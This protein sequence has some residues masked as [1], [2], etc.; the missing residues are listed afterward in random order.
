[1]ASLRV[2]TQAGSVRLRDALIVTAAAAVAVIGVWAELA[3][4]ERTDP[5]AIGAYLLALAVSV[6]LVARRRY[7]LAVAGTGVA[8]VLAY[9][10]LGYPGE[11]P[12][13]GLFVALFT[14]VLLGDGRVSLVVGLGLAGLTGF[15]PAIPNGLL[16]P[17]FDSLYPTAS[18]MGVVV[19]V[20]EAFRR[21]NVASRE[22]L[23][24]AVEAR[25]EEG[26]R[27]LAEERLVIARELHDVLAHTITVITVQSGVALD[28]LVPRPEEARSAL[29][30]I[31]SA[32]REA[33][34]ELR[35]TLGVLRGADTAPSPA[36]PQPG[37]GQVQV[38]VQ[39]ARAAGI[40]IDL[41][42]R[43]DEGWL[44]VPVDLAAYRIVQEALTNVV[45]H[46]GATAVQV[47]VE[48]GS[49][50]LALE[51]TDNGRGPA[52]H[53]GPASHGLVGMRERARSVGGTLDV[54]AG[55]SG[56][57]RVAARLPRG[58]SQDTTESQART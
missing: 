9:H 27:R 8:L 56:G 38:L 37:L 19:V 51:V 4:A 6:T 11:A 16:G 54:G 24:Q 7:P 1:M 25:D 36:R 47:C 12:A 43:G 22:R 26:R 49:D 46:A 53:H 55:P 28:D 13:A 45:R 10:L 32:A 21:V 15:L 5:P 41:A 40:A 58:H 2:L 50:T 17:G 33:T 52:G 31:R 3:Q 30:A 44:P 39:Q 48:Y 23:A 34:G 20:G 18:G 42:V 35:A 14:L 57:F 29:L